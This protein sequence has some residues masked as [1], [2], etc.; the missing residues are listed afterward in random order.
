MMPNDAGAKGHRGGARGGDVVG[1]PV[2]SKRSKLFCV[3]V[4]EHEG[5]GRDGERETFARKSRAGG[6][7]GTFL[8]CRV[9]R[10]HER[11]CVGVKFRGV[12]AL[13]DE[14]REGRSID[15]LSCF[16][17]RCRRLAVS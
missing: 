12:V 4:G 7:A 14:N 15:G 3:S 2:A 13:E 8:V 9:S 16:R 5:R 17:G 10:R 6:W 1:R 11:V